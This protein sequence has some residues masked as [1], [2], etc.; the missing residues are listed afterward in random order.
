MILFIIYIEKKVLQD[1]C[2][3]VITESE[4]DVHF[5][6]VTIYSVVFTVQKLWL[7]NYHIKCPW[8]GKVVFLQKRVTQQKV[9]VLILNHHIFCSNLKGATAIKLSIRVAKE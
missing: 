9:N 6:V 7:R 3:G 5:Q 1:F 8:L 2:V 4:V